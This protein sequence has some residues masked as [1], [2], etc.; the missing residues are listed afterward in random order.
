VTQDDLLYRFRPRMFAIAAELG[1]VRAACR[2][3]GIHLSTY[4]HWKRQLDRHGL[5]ILAHSPCR[6]VPL[7]KIE[8]EEMRFLIPT[9]LVD[10]AEAIHARYRAL[11]F[12]GA[13]GGLRIGGA[14]RAPPKLGRSAGWC[15]HR[16][17]DRTE[18]KGK[19][20]AGPP[21][22]RAAAEPS[23]CRPSSSVSWRNILPPRSGPVATASPPPVGAA[24]GPRA[25]GRA[26]GCR[27]PRQPACRACASTT[28]AIPPWR[29][30]SPPARRP[31]RSPCAG[32]TSVSFTLDCYGHQTIPWPVAG[33]GAIQ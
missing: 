17:R 13:D 15:G 22:T 33:A 25:F 11:V 10:L 31:R 20:I 9:G 14:G 5:E 27:L 7:P 30:G 32:H 23:G 6:N 24:A 16:G 8:R 1:T 2:A 28:S 18:V 12:V 4:Y 29:C 26:L 21:K 19:L 3:M